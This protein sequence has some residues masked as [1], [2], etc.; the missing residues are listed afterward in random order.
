MQRPPPPPR[1]EPDG[2][3]ER[4]RLGSERG[5]PIDNAARAPAGLP[6]TDQGAH[7]SSPPFGHPHIQAPGRGRLQSGPTRGVS[8]PTRE[9]K[10]PAST[11][12]FAPRCALVPRDEPAGTMAP[13]QTTSTTPG[14][15]APSTAALTAGPAMS[16][17]AFLQAY[18]GYG[19]GPARASGPGRRPPPPPA[20]ADHEVEETD[21]EPWL[22]EIDRLRADEFPGLYHPQ[23]NPQ[24]VVYLDHAGATLHGRSQ[25]ACCHAR[26]QEG[27]FGNPHSK[28]PVAR[29]VVGWRR[30]S[31]R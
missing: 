1:R 10:S 28:G 23:R 19:Y 3:S 26:L 13:G 22:L 5:T 14:P 16:K 2:T 20:G 7:L 21:E 18:P 27:L 8:Y 9:H 6:T 24:G 25:L 12:A 29:C 15:T 17:A 11:R 4:A 31:W 30:G